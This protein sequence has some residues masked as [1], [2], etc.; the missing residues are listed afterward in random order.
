MLA[1]LGDL[2]AGLSELEI[3]RDPLTRTLNRRFLSSILLR[4]IASRAAPRW[5]WPG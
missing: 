5:A 4:E 2:F 1:L 3:G